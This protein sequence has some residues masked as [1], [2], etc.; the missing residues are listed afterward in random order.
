VQLQPGATV[1]LCT[2]GLVEDPAAS[3]DVGLE[4]LRAAAAAPV[5]SAEELCDRLLRA[6]DRDGGHDDDTALLAPA[7]DRDEGLAL[8][9]QLAAVPTSG[10]AARHALLDLLPGPE[11]AEFRDV[12]ALLVTELVRAVTRRE[13]T[14]REEPG[15]RRRLRRSAPAG[16]GQRRRS[17][18]I[19]ARPIWAPTWPPTSPP[20]PRPP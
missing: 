1:V 16:P 11:G 2:D 19:T 4:R 6:L 18:P 8:D 3:V 12:A 10:A 14:D 15:G 17:R 20:P 7:A 13:L 9:L 5:R